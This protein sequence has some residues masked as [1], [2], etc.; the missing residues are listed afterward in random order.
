MLT[1]FF[2]SSKDLMIKAIF[3]DID[4]TLASFNTH[5]ISPV[6]REAIEI[7]KSKGIKVF[8]ASGR[9]AFELQILDN[10]EFDGYIIL[11]GSHCFT[12]S[13]Q[14]IYKRPISKE[15]ISRLVKW[16]KNRSIPF[17]FVHDTG[18]FISCV[19]D[20]VKQISKLVEIDVPTVMP[21]EEALEKDIFQLSGYF[22]EGE[23]NGLFVNVLTQCEQ[24]RWCPY[25]TDIIAKGNSKS[26]GIQQILDFH[27]IDIS[28]TMAFG[29]GG[30]DISMLKYVAIGIAMGNASEEVKAAADY[31]TASVDDEGIYQALQHFN[32]I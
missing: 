17:L 4:G 1:A 27:R 9:S 30:N 20:E 19:N 32:L 10:I 11:N 5:Q 12:A 7:L 14:A 31:V 25:F 29:D 22:A 15:D 8:I 13:G 28:E 2:F 26:N 23:E 6:T 21:I 16:L 24:A 3:F 18:Q